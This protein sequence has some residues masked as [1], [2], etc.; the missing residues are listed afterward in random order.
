MEQYGVQ[1]QY[2]LNGKPGR[3]LGSNRLFHNM[4][5]VHVYIARCL[6]GSPKGFG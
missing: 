1:L 3:H 5:D 2:T 4:K 6:L